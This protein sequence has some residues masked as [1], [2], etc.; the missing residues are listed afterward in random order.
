MIQTIAEGDPV[1]V[2]RCVVPSFFS[3]L[4]KV[5]PS[6]IKGFLKKDKNIYGSGAHD[7]VAPEELNPWQQGVD[8]SL[9]EAADVEA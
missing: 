7:K 6:A 1:M 2:A 9:T 3:T 5:L 8:D 4:S